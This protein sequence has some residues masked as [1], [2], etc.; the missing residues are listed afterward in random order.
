MLQFTLEK[1]SEPLW[2]R[3]KPW[4]LAVILCLWT[5]VPSIYYCVFTRVYKGNK[6]STSWQSQKLL[7]YPRFFVNGQIVCLLLCW[8]TW[9][10][11]CK[12]NKRANRL[13]FHHKVFFS[14]LNKLNSLC[15]LV[16]WSSELE[17]KW[18]WCCQA[19]SE[20]IF[21]FI[22]PRDH[23]LVMK[24]LICWCSG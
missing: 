19:E 21:G 8:H 24:R 13:I 12:I 5:M 16:L 6:I 23:R 4:H 7:S 18:N 15:W 2:S 11:I 9:A 10:P 1:N 22:A 20:I 17:V 14:P 3:T